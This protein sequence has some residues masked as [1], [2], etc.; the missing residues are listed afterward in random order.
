MYVFSGRSARIS[1]NL[2]CVLETRG[3]VSCVW[4]GVQANAL[5][6]LCCANDGKWKETD[7]FI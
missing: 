2:P 7:H 5:A 3:R 4:V 1:M 6:H